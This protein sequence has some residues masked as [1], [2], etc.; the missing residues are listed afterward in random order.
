MNKKN[1]LLLITLC[2][3]WLCLPFTAHGQVKIGEGTLPEKGAVLDMKKTTS[4]GYLGGLLLPHV[5]IIDLGFIPEDYTDINNLGETVILG[6]G[7]DTYLPLAGMVVYNTNVVT[8][9]GIYVWDGEK[10]MEIT[11]TEITTITLDAN[12]TYQVGEPMVLTAVVTPAN[13]SKVTYT[14]YKDDIIIPGEIGAT[15]SVAS[16]ATTDVGTYKVKASNTC[17]TITSADKAVSIFDLNEYEPDISGNFTLTGKKCF[18]ISQSNFNI[19]CGLQPRRS[20]DFLNGSRNFVANKPFVYTFTATASFDNLQFVVSD[21]SVL[22]KSATTSGQT[23]ILIFDQSVLVKALG[24]DKD[25]ALTITIYALFEVSGVKKHLELAIAVQDC[26]CPCGAFVGPNVWKE[27]MCHNLGADY[28]L[29]PFDLTSPGALAGGLLGDFYQWGQ[30]TPCATAT[31]PAAAIP[32]WSN[33]PRIG[34]EWIAGGKGTE[35]PC[36]DGFRVPT[37]DEL[38]KLAN[39]TF[40]LIGP[41]QLDDRESGKNY[42]GSLMLPAGGQ[43]YYLDGRLGSLGG[44]ASI[45][46]ADC[47]GPQMWVSTVSYNTYGGNSANQTSNAIPSYG[48]NIRCISEY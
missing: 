11:C 3:A 25:N 37:M 18:D 27:F 31:T 34:N 43:R 4:E 38:R 47:I 36:P 39:N 26:V 29:D 17:S 41:W 33:I 44:S 45:Y 22:L 32:G 24:K 2:C 42:C 46:A 28:S 48:A 8:G 5:A 40:E 13:A 21:P 6:K 10:W 12:E 15:Y 23:H 19:N 14:W 30:K 16:A 9:K 1:Y 35:D 7:V 20:G